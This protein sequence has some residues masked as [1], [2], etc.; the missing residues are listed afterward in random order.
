M[1]PAAAERA[2]DDGR[3]GQKRD[4]TE[5]KGARQRPEREPQ[6][7]GCQDVPNRAATP[8]QRQ[9]SECQRRRGKDQYRSP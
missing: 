9:A 8:G 2:R 7:G 3:A 1:A 5:R 4:L 6:G